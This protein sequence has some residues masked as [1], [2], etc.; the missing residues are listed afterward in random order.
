MPL[1]FKEL[2]LEDIAILH[3]LFAFSLSEIIK[4]ASFISLSILI[5][6]PS[7]STC[8]IIDKLA[9]INIPISKC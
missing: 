1:P 6:H 7:I 8:F 3:K 9:L 2:S 4:E 5:N